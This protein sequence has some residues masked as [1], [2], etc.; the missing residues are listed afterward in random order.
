MVLVVSRRGGVNPVLSFYINVSARVNATVVDS[1]NSTARRVLVAA[2]SLRGVVRSTE[3]R[4]GDRVVGA[5]P[6]QWEWPGRAGHETNGAFR[7]NDRDDTPDR[8][9]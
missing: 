9:F 7:G 2:A 4:A 3:T 5:T 6:I 8:A 1:N